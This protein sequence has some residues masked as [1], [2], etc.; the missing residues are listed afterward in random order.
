MKS[1]TRAVQYYETDRMGIVHNSNYLRIFEEA[2]LDHMAQSGVPYM[3]LEDKGILIPQTSAQ[4]R[5]QNA[6]RYGDVF[7]VTVQLM[8]LT[9]IRLSYGY[10]IVNAGTGKPVAEGM[11]EHCFLD[12][13]R[14]VPVNLEKRFPEVF[15]KL[16]AGL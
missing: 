3:T 15:E 5:Y 7:S 16:K 12:E 8:A 2:R 6:L 14:R 10:R 1:Y 11:T 9:G 13:A 4:L